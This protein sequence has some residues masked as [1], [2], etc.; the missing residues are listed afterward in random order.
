MFDLK[1]KEQEAGA[2]LS[3][4]LKPSWRL[5]FF[6]KKGFYSYSSTWQQKQH[7]LLRLHCSILKWHFFPACLRS[8]ASD[9][10]R[11]DAVFSAHP[12]DSFPTAQKLLQAFFRQE[13]LECTGASDFPC[14]RLMI[15]L[16]R[17]GF[18][19]DGAL[20][21]SENRFRRWK[22]PSRAKGKKGR[23]SGAVV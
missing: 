10:H 17:R 19:D 22:E 23:T 14:E 12:G 8:A 1:G 16:I 20:E 21:F 18:M 4:N 13:Q 7:L 2:E 15:G 5:F 9:A 3:V 11:L 6:L